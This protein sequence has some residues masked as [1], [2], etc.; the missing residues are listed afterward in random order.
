MLKMASTQAGTRCT[1]SILWVPMTLQPSHSETRCRGE[2]Y[3]Y[4]IQSFLAN[5]KAKPCQGHVKA[6]R[7]AHKEHMLQT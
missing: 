1:N 5:G 4:G 2:S 3:W 6:L 7:P